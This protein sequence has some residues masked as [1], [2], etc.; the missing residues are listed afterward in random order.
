MQ[1]T[2]TIKRSLAAEV[3][4]IITQK[5]STFLLLLLLF[6]TVHTCMMK[7]MKQKKG[8]NANNT[9]QITDGT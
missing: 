9:R 3:R 6:K 4:S 7:L 1:I 8:E 5:Y 2:I